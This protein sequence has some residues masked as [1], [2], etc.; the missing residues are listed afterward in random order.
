M[1]EMKSYF[2][3]IN[4]VFSHFKALYNPYKLLCSKHN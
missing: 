1:T 2:F 4:E 3:Y